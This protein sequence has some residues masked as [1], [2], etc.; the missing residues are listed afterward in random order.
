MF[1]YEDKSHFGLAD[2]YKELRQ[3][4]EKGDTQDGCKGLRVLVSG[5]VDPLVTQA[6]GGIVQ[7]NHP[8]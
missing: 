5:I 1:S 6:R 2:G 4:G 3:N 8:T 7:T